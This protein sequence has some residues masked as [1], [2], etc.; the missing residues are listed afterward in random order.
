MLDYKNFSKNA[1]VSNVAITLF[2]AFLAALSI[3]AAITWRYD[4]ENKIVANNFDI[5]AAGIFALSTAIA[6]IFLQ[7]YRSIWRFT[8]LDDIRKLL[9]G[10]ILVTAAA[11]GF[12]MV[13]FNGDENYTRTIPFIALALFFGLLTLSRIAVLLVLNGD[14]RAVLRGKDWAKPPAI[15]VGSASSISNYLRDYTRRSSGHE[16]NISGLIA[17][18]QGLNG[19]SIRGIPVLGALESLSEIYKRLQ[20]NHTLPTTLIAT[21]QAPDKIR[22]YDLVKRAS[23]LGA[24]LV[25]VS[26]GGR[27]K[28]LTRFEAADLIGRPE[29]DLDIGPVR[30][31]IKGKRVMITG[32]GG[33]IGSE[34][35]RQVAALSPA[36]LV[37][38]DSSEFNLYSIDMEL[39]DMYP[40]DSWQVWRLCMGSICH[41]AHMEEIFKAE[42]PE[43]ILHAAAYKHVPL[44][45][46]NPIETLQTNVGG[47]KTLLELAEKYES[48]SFT[49]VSTDKAVLPTNIMGASKRIAEMFMIA[50]VFENGKNVGTNLSSSAVRFGNVLASTGSVVPLFEEQIARGGPVTVTDPN[51]NR[52]F[53]TT[54]E[55]ASLVLQAAAL[56]ATQKDDEASVY[57]LEMGEPVNI[58]QLARQ[59]IRLRGYVPDRD[60]KIIYTGLRPGE[61]VT[62]RLTGHAENLETT[63]VAGVQRFTGQVVDPASV[64]K[65]ID[66]LLKAV[67]ARNRAAIKKALS[68][69]VSDY[70]PNGGLSS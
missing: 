27:D 20:E 7:V 35:T 62:E 13:F 60:I 50:S 34:L 54:N 61:K 66:E 43:I 49:L 17:T 69:L 56:N 51:V 44:S 24:P 15:L 42:A 30:R 9:A 70:T 10:S 18:D 63:Y 32:A 40:D 37:L 67:D 14:L 59:L 41:K 6:W 46:L 11:S 52:F 2:D 19:R 64:Q 57:V 31:F 25:R 12:I 53:M 47:T 21:D 36:K 48:E 68:G 45:E 29:R 26:P 58:S 22:S 16:H 55:A 33:T 38:V 65:Q 5:K 4:F 3:I 1:I 8:A 23:D 28:G 39:R